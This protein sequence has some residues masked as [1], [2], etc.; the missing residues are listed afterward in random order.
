MTPVA[1]KGARV[2]PDGGGGAK[3]KREGDKRTERGEGEKWMVE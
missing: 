2:C 1:V 3:D